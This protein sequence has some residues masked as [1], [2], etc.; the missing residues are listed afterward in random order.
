MW[1]HV[2]D[3]TQKR[4]LLKLMFKT[5]LQMLLSTFDSFRIL[6]ATQTRVISPIIDPKLK[7]TSFSRLISAA[8]EKLRTGNYFSAPNINTSPNKYHFSNHFKFILGMTQIYNG[9]K[10]RL[11]IITIS[12]RVITELLRLQPTLANTNLG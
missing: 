6:D 5:Y 8:V 3:C 9:M 7:G 12:E 11:L 1:C 10:N 4:F 2:N